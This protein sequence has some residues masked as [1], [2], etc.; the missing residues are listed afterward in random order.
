MLITDGAHGLVSDTRR[1]ILFSRFITAGSFGMIFLGAVLFIDGQLLSSRAIA[2]VGMVAYLA[3]LF[4]LAIHAT[5]VT[6][7][8][9]Y[10]IKIGEFTQDRLL[11]L[12]SG[13]VPAF[14]DFLKKGGTNW[15]DEDKLPDMVRTVFSVLFRTEAA[16]LICGVL[17][18]GP[19]TGPL[20]VFVAGIVLVVDRG[21]FASLTDDEL[22][23]RLEK[24]ANFWKYALGSAAI[25]IAVTVALSI[26]FPDFD[27][28]LKGMGG[29]LGSSAAD[30]G[31]AATK[32]V[33][34]ART[35]DW[36][37]PDIDPAW[38]IGLAIA[39][40]ICAAFFLAIKAKS[41]SVLGPIF[42]VF[43]GICALAALTLGTLLGVTAFGKAVPSAA[44]AAAR[45]VAP[46]RTTPTA[47]T[48]AVAVPSI[49]TVGGAPAPATTVRAATRP[50]TPA[51]P[52]PRPAA[53]KNSDLADL[54]GMD[55]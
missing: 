51:R 53:P 50:A 3:G 36:S 16:P 28:F 9:K 19:L 44:P 52:T 41:G 5:A 38:A 33:R 42:G 17:F 8:T 48:T 45:P 14:K 47:T 6:L 55:L 20:C 25:V 46:V 34:A 39:S 30:G 31:A 54:N 49:H 40:G 24:S 35:G 15:F 29:E 1:T 13:L 22:K 27:A 37:F 11:E 23:K 26:V 43:G 12:L 2:F 7:F 18:P 32:A 10:G 4:L 21:L